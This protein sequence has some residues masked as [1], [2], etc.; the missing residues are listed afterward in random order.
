MRQQE[1]AL[2]PHAPGH[3]DNDT[4]RAAAEAIAPAAAAIRQQVAKLYVKTY[5]AGL[6]A[7]EAAA[8]LHISILTIR[9][10]VSELRAG[11]L[12]EKTAD[13]RKNESGQSAVVWRATA[14]ALASI[15]VVRR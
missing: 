2:Y 10:R 8:Q 3:K 1:L 15:P 7:D 9:P 11:E 5:P 14:K 12:V 13:R 6:T 4:S